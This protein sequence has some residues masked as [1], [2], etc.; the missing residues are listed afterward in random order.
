MIREKVIVGEGTEYSLER[1]IGEDVIK[2]IADF[3][4][5]WVAR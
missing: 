4:K 2:D 3:V 5:A 1:H